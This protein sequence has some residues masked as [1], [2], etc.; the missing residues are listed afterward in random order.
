MLPNQFL[1]NGSVNLDFFTKTDKNQL[2]IGEI[3][4]YFFLFFPLVNSNG[5][6]IIKNKT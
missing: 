3:F 2:K 6:V 1:N 4:S 5:M